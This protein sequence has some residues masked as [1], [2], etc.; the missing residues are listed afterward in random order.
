MFKGWNSQAHREFPGK[1]DSSNVSRRNGSREIG[2][3]PATYRQLL[4]KRSFSHSLRPRTNADLVSG[5]KA[6]LPDQVDNPTTPKV[7]GRGG[8][9]LAKGLAQE[10]GGGAPKGSNPPDPEALAYLA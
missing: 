1:F 10:G 7:P 9:R 8:R 5:R 4:H 6:T 2:R 3:I